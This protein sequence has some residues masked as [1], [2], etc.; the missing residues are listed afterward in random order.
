VYTPRLD[1]QGIKGWRCAPAAAGVLRL[2]FR[3]LRCVLSP[4]DELKMMV[5]A[6]GYG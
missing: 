3:P 5:V 6:N 1:F 2:V 4:G